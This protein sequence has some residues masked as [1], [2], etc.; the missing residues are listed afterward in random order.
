MPVIKFP[1]TPKIKKLPTDSPSPVENLFSVLINSYT[2]PSPEDL[3][4]NL[5]PF[6]T[7]G[8]PAIA[9][10][11][12]LRKARQIYGKRARELQ[13]RFTTSE[14]NPLYKALAG[15]VEDNMKKLEV[16]VGA[17][18]KEDL[19]SVRHF[20]EFPRY[21]KGFEKFGGGRDEELETFLNMKGLKGIMETPVKP[22]GR[23]PMLQYGKGSIAVKATSSPKTII[24]EIGHAALV[25]DK[26]RMNR[27]LDTTL[28]S[29]YEIADNTGLHLPAVPTYVTNQLSRVSGRRDLKDEEE[30]LVETVARYLMQDEDY[31]NRAREIGLGPLL[32]EVDE[33]FR[34][35]LAKSI[36]KQARKGKR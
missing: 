3:P 28:D 26:N 15:E 32:D 8:A 9:R 1:E 27:L 7:G 16:A 25:S 34:D 2:N 33:M 17:L 12:L 18:T 11:T 21:V 6:P 14:D 31:L 4:F 24:H 36:K 20:S 35:R 19:K 10:G 29:Y 30:L 23:N 22:G 13:R 5:G